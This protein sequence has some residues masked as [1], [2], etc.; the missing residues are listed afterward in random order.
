MIYHYNIIKK[1]VSLCIMIRGLK[2]C[3]FLVLH[4]EINLDGSMSKSVRSVQSSRLK[5]SSVCEEF[6]FSVFGE[7]DRKEALGDDGERAQQ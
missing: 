7:N 3:Y 1:N 2:W 4:V 5:C 6:L